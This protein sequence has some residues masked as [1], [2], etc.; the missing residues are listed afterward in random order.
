M[1]NITTPQFNTLSARIFDARM[2]LEN[3]VTKADF[4]TALK[5]VSDRVT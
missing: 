3:L 4:D 1:T 2:K 5:K